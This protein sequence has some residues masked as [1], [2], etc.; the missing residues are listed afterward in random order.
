MSYNVT[1]TAKSLEELADKALA[2]GGRLTLA[3]GRPSV[4]A[5]EIAEV[6]LQTAPV[7]PAPAPV[8]AAPAP[9]EPA[10]PPIP[11]Y[12]T[13]V[14]PAVLA[15]SEAKGKQAAAA[16]LARYG[17]NN[18][19]HVPKEQWAALVAELNAVRGA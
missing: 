3:S 9:A 14:G 10:A 18:A 12:A 8:E 11:D 7:E 2:L 5:A 6:A 19:R 16:I 15:L 1:I 4:T 13:V 17:V